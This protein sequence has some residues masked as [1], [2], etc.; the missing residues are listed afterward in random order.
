VGERRFEIE[1]FLGA[2]HGLADR[3][4]DKIGD[5]RSGDHQGAHDEDPDDEGGHDAGWSE[6]RARNAMSATPVTP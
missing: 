5:Q 2:E 3:F 6:G 1:V 4:V